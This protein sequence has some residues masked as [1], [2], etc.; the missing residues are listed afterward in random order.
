MENQ[1]IPFV[2]K[3]ILHVV[4]WSEKLVLKDNCLFILKYDTADKKIFVCVHVTSRSCYWRNFVVCIEARKL[5]KIWAIVK[6]YVTVDNLSVELKNLLILGIYLFL[7]I[8]ICIVQIYC[9]H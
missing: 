9:Y 2:G 3:F 7:E 5:N 8:Y 1:L 6:Y 4:H